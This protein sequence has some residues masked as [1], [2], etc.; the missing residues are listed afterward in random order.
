M[1]TSVWIDFFNGIENK[2]VK[3]LT[4]YIESDFPVFICPIILQ[5]ILQ[6]FIKDRD[7]NIALKLLTDFP[8]LEYDPIDLAIGSADIYRTM[9]KKGIT[10]RKSNDCIIAFLAIYY[11][12]PVLH[13][14]R[15]FSIMADNTSLQVIDM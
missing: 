3:I 15:D 14:D 1:D 13:K 5:E 11:K 7:Y 12:V 8:I 6:G 4:G 9:R 10:V 2:G